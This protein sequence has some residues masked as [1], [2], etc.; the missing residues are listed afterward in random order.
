MDGLLRFALG[1]AN[2]PD[3]TV[4]DLETSLPALARLCRLAKAAEPILQRNRPH[5]EAIMPHLVAMKPDA[6]QLAILVQQAWPDIVAVTPTVE[7][8]VEFA[9]GKI[10]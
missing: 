10:S 2:V 9:N 4:A 3:A 5:L 6:M 1:L 8:L 7:E